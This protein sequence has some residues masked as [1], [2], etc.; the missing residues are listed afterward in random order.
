VYCNTWAY[1]FEGPLAHFGGLDPLYQAAAGLE[2][3]A[4]AVQHGNEPLYYRFGMTDTANAMLSVVGC[5]AALYRQRRTGEGQELWTS[6][7]DGGALFASDA[8]LVDGEPVE[9]PRLDKDQRGIDPLYRLYETQDG[10]IQIAAFRDDD[11]AAL[12]RALA[13]EELRDDGRFATMR[14]RHEHGGALAAVIERCFRTR[15]A[16]SWSLALDDAGVPNEIPFDAKGGELALYDADNV[17]C[18]LTEEYEHPVLGTL[19]QFGRLIDFSETP[20]HI[21]G[22]PPLVG[23][24]TREILRWLGYDDIRIDALREAGVVYEP[25]EH[26]TERFML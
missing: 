9:R 7:L 19:R 10:W 13:I 12:C 16:V 2:Y 6:L 22:P 14:S 3:E 21:A 11:F 25:D 24:H 18:G 15:T 23:Q 4:G 5:L 1:G 17:A 8:L 26:Y 20:G